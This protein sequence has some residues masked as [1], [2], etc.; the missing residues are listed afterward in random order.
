[1][2]FADIEISPITGRLLMAR[3]QHI[4]GPSLTITGGDCAPSEWKVVMQRCFSPPS[5]FTCTAKPLI[6]T[7]ALANLEY[8]FPSPLPDCSLTRRHSPLLG[9]PHEISDAVVPAPY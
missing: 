9:I 1:M 8:Q 6:L 4:L 5:G 2:G 3:S 7:F